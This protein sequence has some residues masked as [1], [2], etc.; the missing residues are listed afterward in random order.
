M[1]RRGTSLV[2]VLG[3]TVAAITVAFAVACL[4]IFNLQFS[5]ALDRREHARNLAESVINLAIAK[6]VDNP[7]YGVSHNAADDITFP[8]QDYPNTSMGFLTFALPPTPNKA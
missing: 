3:L 2:L 8:G 7:N 6:L 4:A 1:G 5:T